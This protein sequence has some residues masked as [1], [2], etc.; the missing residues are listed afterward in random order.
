MKT[1]FKPFQ[2]KLPIQIVFQLPLPC[3]YP[4]PGAYLVT[5]ITK[6]LTQP[7]TEGVLD[8]RMLLSALRLRADMSEP[9]C[10]IV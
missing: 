3:F 8:P 9:A 5:A 4:Q 10:C 7:D 1:A 6:S 2:E